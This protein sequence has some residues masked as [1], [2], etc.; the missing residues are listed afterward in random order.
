[1]VRLALWKRPRGRR[2][3]HLRC[4]VPAVRMLLARRADHGSV[5]AR[6]Q[7]AHGADLLG[8][9][10]GR[11]RAHCVGE[12]YGRGGYAPLGGRG[13]VNGRMNGCLKKRIVPHPLAVTKEGAFILACGI[14][15]RG[16]TTVMG[17]GIGLRMM[18]GST[19]LIMERERVGVGQGNDPNRRRDHCCGSRTRMIHSS[20]PVLDRTA[21][22]F[23]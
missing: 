7:L 19:R 6:A 16:R 3:E 13:V 20:F 9:V 10:H 12:I 11:K 21:R 18:V 22:G 15:M 8:R 4:A 1:M 17:V 14:G 23:F 2:G 5:G